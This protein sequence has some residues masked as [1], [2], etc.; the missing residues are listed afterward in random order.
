MSFYVYELKYNERSLYIGYGHG[1]RISHVLSG[2]S[3]NKYL[4]KFSSYGYVEEELSLKKIYDNIATKEEALQI[5]KECIYRINPLFNIVD[6]NSANGWVE[7]K[8]L[9]AEYYLEQH[10][11]NRIF[12]C[13]KWKK[14]EPYINQFKNK[15]EQLTERLD[16]FVEENDRMSKALKR[17][18]V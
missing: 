9:E 15:I 5:E 18:S 12:D 10:M 2:T 8:R 17:I 11:C 1:K 7:D 3:H 14:S 4:N 13:L 6:H 16:Y